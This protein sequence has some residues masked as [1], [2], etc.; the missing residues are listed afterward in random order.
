[1]NVVLWIPFAQLHTNLSPHFPV[2][3]EAVAPG[4]ANVTC[5][6]ASDIVH[7]LL[8]Q[9][10][11]RRIPRHRRAAPN[12]ERSPDAA[13]WASLSLSDGTMVKL[14]MDGR[15]S[16]S[17]PGV[18]AGQKTVAVLVVS[19]P[20]RPIHGTITPFHGDALVTRQVTG[21][22]PG[23]ARWFIWG[24]RASCVVRPAPSPTPMSAFAPQAVFNSTLAGFANVPCVDGSELA[25]RIFTS[26]GGRCSHVFGLLARFA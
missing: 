10:R 4:K 8:S 18:S 23:P 7:I 22:L 9:S 5:K 6:A 24:E 13:R 3:P 17:G 15:L 19:A 26:Q 11:R 16:G 25:R 12:L 2:I 21:A 1:M 20:C 14:G